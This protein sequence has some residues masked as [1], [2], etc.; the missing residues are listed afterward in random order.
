MYY[1]T[2]LEWYKQSQLIHT[3]PFPLLPVAVNASATPSVGAALGQRQC[4][5]LL[6]P[7]CS[8]S[9]VLT[10]MPG[11]KDNLCYRNFL[12]IWIFKSIR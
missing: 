2:E 1:R 8:I 6:T 7:V 3:G 9:Q 5:V 4:A 12:T 10:L 11:D